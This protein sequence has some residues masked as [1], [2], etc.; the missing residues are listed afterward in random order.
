MDN[1]SNT[2]I[3]QLI[4]DIL[5]IYFYGSMLLIMILIMPVFIYMAMWPY[6]DLYKDYKERQRQKQIYNS[7][8]YSLE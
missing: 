6:I 4:T 5:N 1:Q 3:S 2:E 7:F 8:V